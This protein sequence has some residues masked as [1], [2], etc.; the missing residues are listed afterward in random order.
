MRE[1]SETKRIDFYKQKI[2]KSLISLLS[3]VTEYIFESIPLGTH[4]NLSLT[5]VGELKVLVISRKRLL[6]SILLYK[7]YILL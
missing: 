5:Y 4:I 7:D 3:I 6:K 1:H 2:N